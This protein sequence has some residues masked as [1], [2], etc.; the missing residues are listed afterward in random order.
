VGNEIVVTELSVVTRVTAYLGTT[1][2]VENIDIGD[3]TVTLASG[4]V[5]SVTDLSRIND[6]N[7]HAISLSEL[8][9]MLVN[10][11]DGAKLYVK[12]NV[13]NSVD[14]WM[15]VKLHSLSSNRYT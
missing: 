4:L 7:G 1:E 12:V 2:E 9:Q 8:R 15:R 14:G 5:I 10:L 13:V 3:S 11:P 6:E